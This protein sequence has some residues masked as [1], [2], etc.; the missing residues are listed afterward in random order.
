MAGQ[1][2]HEKAKTKAGPIRRLAAGVLGFALLAGVTFL[3]VQQIFGPGP[4][5]VPETE[6]A[7]EE[8]SFFEDGDGKERVDVTGLQVARD[9]KDHRLLPPITGDGS[10]YD[11]L[12]GLE[13]GAEEQKTVIV[14]HLGDSHI[15]A[16]RIT[17]ELRRRLQAE[18]G[19]AGRGLMMPGFP[20]P[21]YKAP[22]F[23]FEKTGDWQ[24]ANSLREDGVYG[25]TGV[26]LSANAPD[27][28]LT[29]KAEKPFDSAEVSF[30]AGPGQGKAVIMQGE[31]R[32][33]VDTNAAEQS[34]LRVPVGGGRGLSI[35]PT[36]EGK[37]TLLGISTHQA[38]PGL[39]YVNLGIPGAS[40]LTT[41]RWNDQLVAQDL[42]ALSP[43]LV[44]LGYG[45]NEGFQDGLNIE[46]YREAYEGLI[47]KIKQ[48]LP[49]ATLMILGPTDGA[50]LPAYAKFEE[51]ITLRCAPLTSGEIQR[52]DDFLES[53]SDALARWYPPPKL[54]KV[55][56][57]LKETAE[58]HGAL[59]MDLSE[60]MGGPC[61]I[62]RWI[63]AEP[64]MALPDHVHL[65][66]LGAAKVGKVI[67]EK[68]M[69]D[70]QIYRNTPPNRTGSVSEADGAAAP[71]EPGQ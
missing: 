20:F 59:Y 8:G 26:S 30:L 14:L 57:V 52:Y 22:G 23:S 66:D 71:A 61:S 16:D 64:R 15:A 12:L 42:K 17:G 9:A 3:A 32:Q 39:R 67:F 18:F 31:Q 48:V 54:Q 34:V 33:T 70:Y 62:R 69:S 46:A 6:T 4:E 13:T 35:S 65:S 40:A 49:N 68:L 29:L 43:Q 38:E 24:A 47:G 37:I 53:K 56:E 36:G 41:R 45:T 25:I 44:V 2:Q 21:Y 58:E 11:A 60:V 27:A 55:R 5:T 19:D 10:F 50:K 51:A 63:L 7:G 1:T 28:Q